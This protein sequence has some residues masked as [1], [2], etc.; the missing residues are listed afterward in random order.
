MEATG[1]EFVD[2][3]VDDEG[4]AA[5]RARVT[6][7][8]TVDAGTRASAS[9]G[10]DRRRL[11]A[12]AHVEGGSTGAAAVTLGGSIA[13]CG[14]QAAATG[15][16][17][18]PISTTAAT[19][20]GPIDF[21]VVTHGGPTAGTT[22]NKTPNPCDPTT[23]DAAARATEAA[24]TLGNAPAP[25]RCTATTTTAATTT[26][27]GLAAA[28]ATATGLTEDEVVD[29]IPE[30]LAVQ[31]AA[32]AA[33]A[34]P[35]DRRRLDIDHDDD[36]ETDD[37]SEEGDDEYDGFFDAEDYDSDGETT[38]LE[39]VIQ[40]S[41]LP[42]NIL[43]PTMDREVARHVVTRAFASR[44]FGGP[45]GGHS[46]VSASGGDREVALRAVAAMLGFQPPLER[47]PDSVSPSFGP[48]TGHRVGPNGSHNVGHSPP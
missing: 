14:G 13:H 3:G 12:T 6:T 28:A 4:N 45:N 27:P 32:D 42:C 5:K 48:L 30:V 11:S 38:R 2:S 21:T 18:G 15:A 46:T 1:D 19:R 17:G 23:T 40:L 33:A 34:A 41:G 36:D 7:V 20:G 10:P 43:C 26:R 8:R 35:R 25:S 44:N 47:S 16:Q 39:R 31:E 22:D 37:E 24:T 29:E 9:L